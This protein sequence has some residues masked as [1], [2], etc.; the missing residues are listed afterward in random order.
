M[1]LYIKDTIPYL[2][3]KDLVP[4][5]LKM[6][7]FE[8]TKQQNKPF[9]ITTWYRPTNSEFNLINNFELFV[10]KCD[11][12][13]KELILIGYLNCDVDKTTSDHQRTYKNYRDN[14]FF[15]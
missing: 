8:I 7:C 12:K 6:I 11:M 14:I 2:E 10:F 9:L 1:A 15:D 3:R 4:D 13:N 5:K